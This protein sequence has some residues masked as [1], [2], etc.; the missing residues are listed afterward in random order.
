MSQL[1]GLS[2]LDGNRVSRSSS[3]VN[4][5]EFNVNVGTSTTQYYQIPFHVS[6]Y[7]QLSIF[8]QG[9]NDGSTVSVINEL[10]P[11]PTAGGGSIYGRNASTI[12]ASDYAITYEASTNR[13]K[14]VTGT[15]LGANGSLRVLSYDRQV[16]NYSAITDP[17]SDAESVLP[18]TIND[19][20]KLYIGVT[21]DGGFDASAIWPVIAIDPA[22]TNA[23]HVNAI[24]QTKAFKI[25]SK[26]TFMRD[27]TGPLSAD[28][29]YLIEF[30]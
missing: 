24:G 30:H 3:I 29:V 12:G 23:W 22:H 6:N 8:W 19:L 25:T 15:T 21:S 18:F 11:T 5:A 1:P 20:S 13:V 7:A 17:G 27:S 9:R 14:V 2:T 10:I 16:R 26:N 4:S 28:D